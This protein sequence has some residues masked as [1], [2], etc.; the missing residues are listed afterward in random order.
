MNNVIDMMV[1]Q[2]RGGLQS[3]MRRMRGVKDAV[4][5]VRPAQK[6]TKR[7]PFLMRFSAQEQAVFAKRL[8]MILRSGMPI[9]EGLHMLSAQKQSGSAAYI[10]AHLIEYVDNGQPLSSG[11]EKFKNIF[12]EFCINIVRVGE[13]SGT[14][15]ENLDYLAEE[16]KKKTALRKKVIGALVYPAVIIAATVGISLVL[17]VYIFPKITPIFQS[18]KTQLPL[19][20]RILIAFSNFLI[21][22]GGWLLMG[23]VAAAVAYYFLLRVR[24]FHL[25]VDSIL[26]RIPLIGKISQYYNLANTARTLGLLIKSDMGIV[27]AFGIVTKSS[28]NL[29][30]HNALA[31]I[32]KD[33]MKGQKISL[34]LMK[35]PALFPP[36]FSQMI[37]VGEQTGNLSNS[38]LYLSDMYEE[39]ISDLTKNMTTLIE[40]ILMVIMGIIVGFIAISIITPIYGITSS[41]HT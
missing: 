17:T 19:T 4:R 11:L 7:R 29:A 12:G 22:D 35:E 15:H 33:I 5:V 20:T 26:L 14:L 38:L 10:Y 9:M 3:L 6:S 28:R 16:L 24:Q 13:G 27:P 40:P 39:E 23:L 41:L 8:G 1:T 34:Q 2:S 32:T 37:M 18:F 25:I 36:L 31:N 30:Y 21:H